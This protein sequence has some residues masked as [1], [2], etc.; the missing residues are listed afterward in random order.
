MSEGSLPEATLADAAVFAP[1]EKAE[2]PPPEPA[3][4]AGPNALPPKVIPNKEL[5]A[6]RA[7][8][9]KVIEP[10]PA[11]RE[12]IE[13][14]GKGVVVVMKLCVNEAGGVTGV[15]PL[16]SSGHPGYDAKIAREMKL[17]TYRPYTVNGQATAVCSPVTLVFKP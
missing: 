4:D 16:K 12:A 14:N 10:D 15:R 1:P 11:D 3:A 17:W 9:N 5:E 13:R 2:A 6:L 8:G 7:G